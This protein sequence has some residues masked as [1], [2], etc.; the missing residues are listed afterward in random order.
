[1]YNN[2][3]IHTYNNGEYMVNEENQEDTP[4]GDVEITTVFSNL[5]KEIE[6][7]D[8]KKNE[9]EG[10]IQKLKEHLTE[11][12]EKELELRDK[13]SALA[14]E[15]PGLNTQRIELEK[16]LNSATEKLEK[17]KKIFKDLSSVWS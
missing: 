7:L 11:I 8:G 10:K 16:Q 15:E 2:Q 6:A 3:Y 17:T 9:M 4:K 14:K 1:M 13:I 5:K 12:R